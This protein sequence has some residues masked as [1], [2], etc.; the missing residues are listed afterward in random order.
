MYKVNVPSVRRVVVRI[1]YNIFPESVKE[2]LAIKSIFIN[3]FYIGC[4]IEDL[5]Q[6]ILLRRAVVD[7]DISIK[8]CFTHLIIIMQ[9]S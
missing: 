4:W 1:L 9:H 8:V 2:G 6:V 5:A 7:F 3:W